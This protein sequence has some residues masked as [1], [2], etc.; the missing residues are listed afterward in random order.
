MEKKLLFRGILDLV[1]KKLKP[2][3]DPRQNHIPIRLTVFTC[4]AW[5]CK[6]LCFKKKFNI[7]I[8]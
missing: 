5:K 3:P 6:K 7:F 1:V 4:D 2:D 8:I